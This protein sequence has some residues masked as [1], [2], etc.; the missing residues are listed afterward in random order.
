M[1]LVDY[2]D[3]FQAIMA[4]VEKMKA[5]ELNFEIIIVGYRLYKIDNDF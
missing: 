5:M 4:M 1:Q 2:I 3:Y